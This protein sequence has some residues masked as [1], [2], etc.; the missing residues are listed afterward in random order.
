MQV[1]K[2]GGASV[3]DANS[4]RNVGEI[5]KGFA[6]EKLLIVISAMGKTTNMLERLT[7]A[8]VEQTGKAKQIFDEFKTYHENI[9]QEL[10][11]DIQPNGFDDIENTF[12]EL[13][14]LIGGNPEG[15]YDFNYDQIVSFGE[16]VSTKIVS[17]YLNQTN[18]KNRWVDARNFIHT[19]AN[20]REGRVDWEK[21]SSLIHNKL[22]PLIEKQIIITQGFIGNSNNNNTTTLGRE[23]SDYS[24]AIFAYALEASSQTIWKDVTGVLNADP[25]RFKDTTNIE[26]LTYN[27]AIELAYYGATVIHPKTI[28]PLQSKNIPL[29][30]KSFIDPKAKGT[31]V[32]NQIHDSIQTPIF[33]I[34]DKQ[35]LVSISSKDFSFIVEENLSKIFEFFATHNIKTNLMQNSAIS[36]SACVDF[37]L[38]KL[39]HLQATL[40]AQFI[41]KVNSDCELFTARNI[42]ENQG[43]EYL[44]GKKILLEQRTRSSAQFVV[45]DKEN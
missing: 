18:V 17:I 36:F 13:E 40:S 20:Y 8:Y 30:V 28:Q 33:I 45:S 19:D 1:F 9:I 12:I 42:Q 15:S 34:K 29:F 39:K 26:F 38:L 10:I 2:F 23:G 4:V 5:V 24:A 35:A 14:C 25:K 37:D 21:T 32:S 3:K 41:V 43:I 27:E 11:E 6:Q 44:K 7:H 31:L 16:I 22:K